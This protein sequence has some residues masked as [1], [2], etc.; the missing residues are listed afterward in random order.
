MMRAVSS[1][2]VSALVANLQRSYARI[3][4]LQNELSTGTKINNPSDDPAGTQRSLAYRSDI[5]DNEQ[6]QRNIRESKG[7][8]NMTDTALGGIEEAL[9]N[10][11]ALATQGASTVVSASEKRIIADEIDQVLEHALGLATTMRDG[12]YIFGGTDTGANP[13]IVTRNTEGHVSSITVSPTATGSIEREVTDGVRMQINATATDIFGGT[14]SPLKSLMDLRDRLMNNDMDGINQSIN[15]LEAARQHTTEIRS[16]AGAKANRLDLT[17]NILARLVADLQG[18]LSETEDVDIVE[19]MM[20]LQQEQ[21]L[22]QAA[23]MTANSI[24]PPTLAQYLG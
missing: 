12:K 1:T 20:N 14:D 24:L 13:L 21:A 19:H 7:W 4:K 15:D 11:M 22:Y 6:F 9:I 8:F 5:R 23:A 18:V 16:E 17:E 3:A 10:A 2:S